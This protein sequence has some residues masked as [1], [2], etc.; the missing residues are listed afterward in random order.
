V[1]TSPRYI[2]KALLR[3]RAKPL[4]I[5]AAP[6]FLVLS[7]LGNAAF[8]TLLVSDP[9]ASISVADQPVPRALYVTIIYPL[10]LIAVAISL[11]AA[12]GLL[13]ERP[14]ARPLLTRGAA[15]LLLM[16]VVVLGVLTDLGMLGLLLHTGSSWILLGFIFWYFY[17]NERVRAYYAHLVTRR[18]D[19]AR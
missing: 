18:P 17:E 7:A 12:Y 1:N 8:A 5:W 13:A 4:L 10:D 3:S 19:A 14:F 9:S 2:P 16:Y 15:G 6:P 11:A